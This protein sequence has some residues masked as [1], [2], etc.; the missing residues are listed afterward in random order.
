MISFILKKEIW[1]P[2][3]VLIIVGGFVYSFN[4]DNKLFWDDD[5]WI[6]NNNFVHQI[7][8]DNI[9]FWLTHNTL[10]GVGLKSNYYR[11]FLFFTFALNYE[12]SGIKPL[13]YHLTSNL[14]H[15]FNG[16][17]VFWLIGRVF[18]RK[19]LAFL[20][21][22]LFLI[23]P[24]QTEAVTYISGRGDLLVAMFMLLSLILFHRAEV[25]NE[26]WLSIKKIL[27][28]IFL[29]LGLL[30]RETGIIFPVLALAFYV[31]VL[32][33]NHSAKAGATGQAGERFIK[34]LKRGLVKIWPYFAVVVTYGILRLSVLNFLNT[35]NFYLKPDIYSE[36]LD[37]RIFT[38][39]PI[40]WEYLKLLIIP[41]GLHMERGGIVYTSLFQWPVWP[42]FL[43]LI[44]LLFW[45][46]WLYKKNLVHKFT[47]SHLV[48]ISDV[49]VWLFGLSWFFFALGPV[50]GITPIN[51]LMYEHWLYLPM[52]GFWFII[53]FYLVKL[54]DFLKSNNKNFFLVA[55][56]LSLV[57]YFS[58]LSYQSIRRNI[59]WG[60]QAE[61]YKDILKYEPESAR[62]NNNLGNFYYNQGEKEQAES[63]Y[64]KAVESGDA[65]A[66]PYYNLGSILQSK[67]DI[68]GA[69]KLYEKAIEI[70]PNLYYPYQNLAVIY[71][72][73][74]NLNKAVENVEILKSLI[75]D[76]PRVYYNSALIYIA[77]NNK[78]QA[79]KDLQVGLKYTDLDP[80]TGELIKELIKEL[81]K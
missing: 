77:L 58:F 54:F 36:N 44:G 28:V 2:V 25:K 20:V 22:V 42:V 3:V 14:I 76:N 21:A 32:S 66:Q 27:S 65:F 61:F 41:T 17:L 23:H 69:M 34:S 24:L 78:G 6:I 62:I 56:L 33:P 60:K 63:Y 67:G 18:K 5:D 9:K 81:Q 50:S 47:T 70:N 45:L 57:F 11:P 59:V 52:V 7:S 80:Q 43:G 48:T 37:V 1:L 39:L 19:L 72:Q 53:S 16:L 35:L 31:L 38:F 10:A 73:Q 51:A 71:A 49:G 55:C 40:L 8:W 68:F 29:V 46:R 12:I 30:S 79:L 75:P 74:G 26:S 4:L 64:R 15:I 13:A